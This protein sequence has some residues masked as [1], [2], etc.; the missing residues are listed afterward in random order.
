MRIPLSRLTLIERLLPVGLLLAVLAVAFLTLMPFL[1]AL[2]WAA[3]LA[4]AIAP[5]FEWLVAKLNGRRLLAAWLMG[6]VLFLCILIPAIGLAR[7]MLAYL[8]GAL[9]WLESVSVVDSISI[10]SLETLP[11]V[12]PHLAEIW[13]SLFSD[14]AG[15]ATH[16]EQELK[17]VLL[18]LLH[19][20]DLLGVFVFEF[21]IGILLAMILVYRSERVAQLAS[22]LFLK[23]GGKFAH[24]LAVHSVAT[25][26]QAVRGVLGAA[27]AQTLV[28]TVSYVIAGV[29]GWMILAGITFI[30]SLIQ[31]GPVLIWLP[32]SIWLFAGD[33]VG[34]AAFV[35][36][37]GLI[38]VNL[39]DNLVRPML[40]SRDNDLPASLAFLG[41][42]G[43]MLEFGV[44]GVF[45]G[46][47]IVAVA[48]ELI[49]KWLE[50]ETLPDDEELSEAEAA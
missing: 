48:Y 50:P 43:G 13:Q 25:T 46:P 9:G 30:L 17:A 36:L 4:V 29:P 11:A 32:I 19:E 26:R 12:G 28:A 39:T 40:V 24:R 8:P 22:K 15:T 37:W 16:F 6:L 14:A 18:W 27:L 23:I 2:L 1:P 44:V 33:Q 5:R 10:G 38:V 34:M 21:A 3:M 49:L 41:A 35:F 31:V 7:T 45:L 20:F 42:L 47:V